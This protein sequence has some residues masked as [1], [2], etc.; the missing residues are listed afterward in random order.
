MIRRVLLLIFIL[1]VLS[2]GLSTAVAGRQGQGSY[3]VLL[4][5]IIRSS[6]SYWIKAYNAGV[7]NYFVDGVEAGGGDFII[8]GATGSH[9][10][11]D[12]WALRI[13]AHGVV[14]WQK[15]FGFGGDDTFKAVAASADG[16]YVLAGGKHL[17]PY[18]KEAMV[19]KVDGNGNVIWQKTYGSVHSEVL[20]IQPTNDGGYV[21]AGELRLPNYLGYWVMKLDSNGVV[22]WQ[23][24]YSRVLYIDNNLTAIKQTADGGYVVGGYSN[25]TG[26]GR[27]AWVL[28]L[29]ANGN[30]IWQK[31][32][33]QGIES[34][35]YDL[36]VTNDGGIIMTGATNFELTAYDDLW[37]IKLDGDG[38]IVWN[39]VFDAQNHESGYTVQQTSDNGYLVGGEQ[40]SQHWL[41]KFNSNGTLVWQKSYQV[42]REA[43]FLF[44]SGSDIVIGGGLIP[45]G[46][47]PQSTARLLKVDSQGEVAGCPYYGPVSYNVS[48][49]AVVVQST[50]A[51]I[52]TGLAVTASAGFT[53]QNI[54]A[55]SSVACEAAIAP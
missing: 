1:S 23:K 54:S 41:L 33:R 52:D 10:E 50:Q 34:F 3:S 15:T 6:P 30:I 45:P 42:Y 14:L 22:S 7:L 48:S 17:A 19:V 36:D 29:D 44:E 4:P 49:P 16:S 12:A 2:A 32:Y 20:D 47:P 37:F 26:F 24:A 21:V 28:K 35:I 38:S 11:M 8:G 31:L 25:V 46:P 55:Q 18:D 40:G 27:H 5:V 51:V 43:G 13:N 9:Q 39:W 53:P